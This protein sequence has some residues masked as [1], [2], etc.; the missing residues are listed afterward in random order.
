MK[1]LKISLF[2]FAISFISVNLSAQIW[3]GE[4]DNG[5]LQKET[6]EVGDFDAIN[7]GGGIDLYLRQ[8]DDQEVIVNASE[9]FIKRIK[10]EVKNGTLHLSV[11][12]G[13]WFKN[14]KMEVHVTMD[15]LVALHASGGSDVYGKGTFQAN[16]F[17]IHASGGSDIEM[18]LE[19]GKLEC[20][21]SGGSDTDLDGMVENLHL[22][23]SGGSDFEG[24]GLV[25][26]HAVVEASGGSDSS[27]Y[28]SESIEVHA[29]GSS[30]VDYKGN[31]S[32]TNIK[33]SGSSDVHSH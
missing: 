29:S 1:T 32:K 4:K 20:H 31:P 15:K 22:H 28:A 27:V 2:I 18:N 8:A 24:Y 7:V 33:S 17:E 3:G 13:R 23:A 19:V 9:N 5:S 11:E 30:D 6:R 10:T 14:G 25:A 21:I 16:D 12:K 26:K